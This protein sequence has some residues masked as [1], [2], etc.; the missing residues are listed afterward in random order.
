MMKMATT[1]GRNSGYRKTSRGSRRK[2]KE[3]N[4]LNPKQKLA[5]AKR[6][7]LRPRQVEVW[8]QNRRARRN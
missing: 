4:T 5:L 1:R 2:F 3:H 8:F 6:L 7:G